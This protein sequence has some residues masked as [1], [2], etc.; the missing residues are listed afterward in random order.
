M[1]PVGRWP[2][3]SNQRPC[4][5]GEEHSGKGPRAGGTLKGLGGREEARGGFECQISHFLGALVSLCK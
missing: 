5:G 1:P 2:C 4:E 3:D